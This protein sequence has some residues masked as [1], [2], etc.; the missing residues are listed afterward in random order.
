MVERDTGKD[1]SRGR[2]QSNAYGGE[3][4]MGRP[5]GLC[6]SPESH[7]G[8]YSAIFGTSVLW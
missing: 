6:G 2:M 1:R 7:Q 3:M 5:G 8:K 4:R